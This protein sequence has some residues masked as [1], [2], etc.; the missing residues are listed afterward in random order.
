MFPVNGSLLMAPLFPRSGPGESGSPTLQ[1]IL[2]CYD[3]PFTHP[4]VTYLFRFRGP[5][6]PPR[7][8]SR[9]LCLRSQKVGGRLPGRGRCSAGDPSAG[10]FS[11]GRERDIPGSQTIHP[12]PLPRS[13]T[14]AEP[15]I[16]RLLAVSSMLPPLHRKRRLQRDTHIGAIAG[17]QHLLPTLHEWC[18]HHPCKA[19]FRLAGSPL[20]GGS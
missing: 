20:P 16:P 4:S 9:S 11:R 8:V 13:K 6:Y 3:F 15:T 2:R 7:F 5:R 14:P 10:L 1:V 19:R 17:L 12:M 18:Y